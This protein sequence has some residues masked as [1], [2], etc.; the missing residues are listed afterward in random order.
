MEV[1]YLVLE[2]MMQRPLKG[3]EVMADL[4]ME[5]QVATHLT[6]ILRILQSSSS[7]LLC[8]QSLCCHSQDS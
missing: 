2:E 1:E 4:T 3:K 8:S 7:A 5:M 6:V